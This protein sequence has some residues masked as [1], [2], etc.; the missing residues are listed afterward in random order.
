M[1]S[2]FKFAYVL[3]KLQNKYAQL[4]HFRTARKSH[5]CEYTIF[6]YSFNNF[7]IAIFQFTSRKVNEEEAKL[8]ELRE[9]ERERVEEE[10]YEG[11]LRQETERLKLKGFTP[12]V[13]H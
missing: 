2:S 3:F 5:F 1:S 7:I 10:E 12:R 11:F 4:I 6:H 13:G 9:L 8:R